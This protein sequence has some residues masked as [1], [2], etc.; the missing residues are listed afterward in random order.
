MFRPKYAKKQCAIF[1]KV[2]KEHSSGAHS[3]GVALTLCS[4]LK[5]HF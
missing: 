5:T 1:E 4:H 3:L 2:T